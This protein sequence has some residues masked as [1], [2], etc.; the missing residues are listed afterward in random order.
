MRLDVIRTVGP[1]VTVNLDRARME[2]FAFGGLAKRHSGSLALLRYTA[3]QHM[4]RVA[5]LQS[6]IDRPDREPKG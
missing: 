6:A 1:A 3:M 4:A 5:G 2:A